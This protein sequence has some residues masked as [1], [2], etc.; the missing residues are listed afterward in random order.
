MKKQLII[1]LE[2]TL[3]IEALVD[4]LSH[5]I[6]TEASLQRLRYDIDTYDLNEGDD[7]INDIL[8]ALDVICDN[9]LSVFN[10]HSLAELKIDHVCLYEDFV[11]VD[12]ATF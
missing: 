10:A 11:C 12:I 5:L 8:T 3:G 7:V 1:R 9:A 4:D 2:D 6:S